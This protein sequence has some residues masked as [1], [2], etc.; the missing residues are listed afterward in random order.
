MR[1]RKADAR[2]TTA[3]FFCGRPAADSF[4]QSLEPRVLVAV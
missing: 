1:A 3:L 4:E 2:A